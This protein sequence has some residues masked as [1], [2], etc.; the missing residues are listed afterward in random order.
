MGYFDIAADPF[1]NSTR[2]TLTKYLPSDYVVGSG[3]FRLRNAQAGLE[4]NGIAK[5]RL[6]YALGLVNGNSSNGGDNNSERT[7]IGV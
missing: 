4:V 2:R 5:S 6:R 3:G 1:R 7:L